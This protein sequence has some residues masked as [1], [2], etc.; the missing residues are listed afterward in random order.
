YVALGVCLL[1]VFSQSPPQNEEFRALQ[2]H[3]EREID[4][5]FNRLFDGIETVRQWDERKQR[6]RGALEKMLWHN[7]RFPSRPPPARLAG[8]EERAEYTV[9][10]LVL[11][12]APRLYVTANLFL[13]KNGSKPFPVILYQCG[14][15]N[16]SAYSHHGAWFAAHGV[17]TLVMDNI[18]AGE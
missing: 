3:F 7:R 14:H 18:E 11:E 10:S 5:R 2:A 9:E 8:R 4:R 13:P 16:K 17:A 15:A 6:I 1:S 12:T